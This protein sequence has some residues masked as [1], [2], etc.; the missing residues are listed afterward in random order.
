MFSTIRGNNDNNNNN[1][2]DNNI[3]IVFNKKRQGPDNIF[4]GSDIPEYA[5]I[6]FQ[7]CEL[8]SES[9]KRSGLSGAAKLKMSQIVEKV[10][11]G[12]GA[13]KFWYEMIL[14]ASKLFSARDIETS[15]FVIGFL[16]NIRGFFG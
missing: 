11:K 13:G 16:K 9:G 2:N 3:I 7:S 15:E 1:N 14:L 8:D 4:Q 10:Q 12:L 6:I 5:Q